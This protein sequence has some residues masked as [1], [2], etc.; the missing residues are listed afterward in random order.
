[1]KGLYKKGLSIIKT[2]LQK[3]KEY[4]QKLKA[5][6][7]EEREKQDIKTARYKE[8][9]RGDRQRKVAKHGGVFAGAFS[10]FPV[11]K[12]PIA[13]KGRRKQKSKRQ[14]SMPKQDMFDIDIPI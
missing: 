7:M 5:I 8:Q 3:R 6:R 1:M 9:V 14:R 13:S 2:N 12:A 11:P 4:N 10:N